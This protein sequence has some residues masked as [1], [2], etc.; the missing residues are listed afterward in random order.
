M[1]V[2]ALL[3]DFDG[4]LVQRD[5]LSEVIDLV[6]KKIE[7]QQIDADFQSG[8]LPGVLGLIQRINLLAGVSVKQIKDK[9]HEDLSLIEGARELIQYCKDTSVITILASGS[10]TP[11]LEVYQNELGIDYIVGPKPVIENDVVT[12]ISE[13]DFPKE[14]NFKVVGITN[15]LREN[16]IR[17]ANSVAVGDS[18]GDLPMFKLANYAIGINPK[19]NLDEF[20][21]EKVVN[22]HQVVEILNKIELSK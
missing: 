21:D 5:M 8:K 11:I 3:L 14:G 13:S 9:V 7:S 6:G 20:I 16:N 2:R 12:G 1:K 18:R 10:I 4:T 19:V 15:I 17:N 22:L